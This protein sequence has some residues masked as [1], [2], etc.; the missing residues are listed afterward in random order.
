MYIHIYIYIYHIPLPYHHMP[1]LVGDTLLAQ[2]EADDEQLLAPAQ[3]QAH[4][5][6]VAQQLLAEDILLV[7]DIPLEED[8]R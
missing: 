7:E 3:A 8:T 5:L 1:A 4:I 6:L 2:V